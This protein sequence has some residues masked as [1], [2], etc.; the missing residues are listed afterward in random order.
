M[1]VI[2]ALVGVGVVFVGLALVS[3]A[4]TLIERRSESR[5]GHFQ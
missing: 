5:P 1:V 2:T 4:F 3:A